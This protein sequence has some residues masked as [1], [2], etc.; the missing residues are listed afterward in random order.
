MRGWPLAIVIFFVV[1]VLMNA[2]FIYLAVT[3]DDPVVE[4]YHT[5]E[6]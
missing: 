6:R 1:V 3:S 4:S 5:L 2:V